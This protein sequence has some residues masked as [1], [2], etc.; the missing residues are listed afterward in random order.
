MTPSRTAARK[1]PTAWSGWRLA[2]VIVGFLVFVAVVFALYVRS[3]DGDYR[4]EQRTAIDRA[5]R[6]AGLVSVQSASKHV[7]QESVWVVQGK[8][9]SG[10]DW[11]VWLRDAG[12]VKEKAS[13]GLTEERA[14]AAFAAAHP[15]KKIVRMLPGWFAD[16][17]AWEI[18][19]IDDEETSRQ[20]I[21]FLSFKD[22]TELKAYNLIS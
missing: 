10:E 9:A 11:F 1:R 17:P 19:Y 12:I 20:A 21:L 7:W 13:D 5:K 4:G 16:Q 18:R 6:E 8:D 22:G 3:A 14:E 2:I 15:G